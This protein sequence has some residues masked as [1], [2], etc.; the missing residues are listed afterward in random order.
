MKTIFLLFFVATLTGCATGGYYT[1]ADYQQAAVLNSIYNNINAAEA[2]REAQI[3]YNYQQT[4]N[5]INYNDQQLYNRM[6]G[7]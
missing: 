7:K 4:L 2:A 1:M 3:N 6:E 5:R